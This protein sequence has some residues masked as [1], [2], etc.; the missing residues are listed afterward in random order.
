MNTHFS[1]HSPSANSSVCG[2]TTVTN[3]S[4]WPDTEAIVTD[5]PVVHLTCPAGDPVAIAS[6]GVPAGSHMVGN[7]T[8]NGIVLGTLPIGQSAKLTFTCEVN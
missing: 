2:S 8:G 4:L 7:L 6:S 1:Q 3:N 5:T